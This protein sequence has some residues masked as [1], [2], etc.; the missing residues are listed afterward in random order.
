MYTVLLKGCDFEVYLPVS[1]LNLVKCTNAGNTARFQS[2]TDDDLQD[3]VVKQKNKSTVNNTFYDLKL[4]SS[5]L[6]IVNEMLSF[7]KQSN[8]E[9]HNLKASSTRSVNF[10]LQGSD[11]HRSICCGDLKLCVDHARQEYLEFEGRQKN[12][13]RGESQGCTIS[14]AQHVDM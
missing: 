5:Y 12:Q 2:V 1:R 14:Q 10:G 9:K 6:H 3:F 4:L 7:G 8:C 11:K 13:T